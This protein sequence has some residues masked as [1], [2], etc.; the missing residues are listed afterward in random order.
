MPLSGAKMS[1]T[2]KETSILGIEIPL[3]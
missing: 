2:V 1:G 3:K